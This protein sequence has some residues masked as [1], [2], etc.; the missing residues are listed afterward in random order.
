MPAPKEI[1]R[2][3]NI[4]F[5]IFEKYLYLYLNTLYLITFGFECICILPD[6]KYLHLNTFQCI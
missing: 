2:E 3:K 6:E 1:N 4:L 5:T